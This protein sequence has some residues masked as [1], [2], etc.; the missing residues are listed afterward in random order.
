MNINILHHLGQ[1]SLATTVFLFVNCYDEHLMLKLHLRSLLASPCNSNKK[2]LIIVGSSH[3]YSSAYVPRM[4]Y[5]HISLPPMYAAIWYAYRLPVRL[6]LFFF[7][8]KSNTPTDQT[9]ASHSPPKINPT[10]KESITL[11]CRPHSKKKQAISTT[12]A[13][14]TTHTK[15]HAQH[16]AKRRGGAEGFD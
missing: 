7:A 16:K 10:T 6:M 1:F 12:N 14:I 9:C 11:L 15:K 2:W 5:L 3:N 4:H 8:I 13:A